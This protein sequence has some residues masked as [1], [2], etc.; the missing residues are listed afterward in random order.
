MQ[1]MKGGAVLNTRQQAIFNRGFAAIASASAESTTPATTTKLTG[2]EA[3]EVRKA[4]RV[5]DKVATELENL[6]GKCAGN[7]YVVGFLEDSILNF[8]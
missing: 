4:Q 7:K 1:S 3:L 5:N 8:I 6:G 2:P